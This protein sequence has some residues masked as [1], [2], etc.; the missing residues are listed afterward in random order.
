MTGPA[1]DALRSRAAHRYLQAG[2]WAHGFARG[3]MAGDPMYRK[4]LDL[5]AGMVP[6]LVVDVGCGEGY[7]LALM[8]EAV[9]TT[10]LFGCDH[11][12]K[13]L[14]V[15]RRALAGEPAL[16]LVEGDAR[17]MPLP[18]AAAVACLDVLHY[19]PEPDQDVLLARMASTLEPGG[20]L[21]VRD[22]DARGGWRDGVTR[23]SEHVARVVGRHR[24]KGLF[25]RP[26]EAAIATLRRE[27]LVVEGST[28]A[29]G[30]PFANVLLVARRG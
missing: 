19:L 12:P 23:V 24:G 15:A 8:R 18:A 26:A 14:A 4:V 1:F 16:D 25:F 2:R 17:H 11:D 9:P 20:T 13:R 5:L 27:G 7:L 29:D 21:L 10:P 28:C 6:G 22:L 30:T 3:K